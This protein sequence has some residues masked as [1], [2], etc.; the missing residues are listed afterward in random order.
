M[1]NMLIAYAALGLLAVATSVNA[2]SPQHVMSDAAATVVQGVQAEAAVAAPMMDS[3][4]VLHQPM[5]QP[6]H[7]QYEVVQGQNTAIAEPYVVQQHQP[8]QHY[9]ARQPAKKQNVFQKLMELERKK[10]AWLRKTFLGK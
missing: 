7:Q 1:R 8:V 2:Q 9:H 5:H 10:N 6:M 4:T 3:G